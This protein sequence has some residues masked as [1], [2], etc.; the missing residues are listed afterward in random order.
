[1]IYNFPSFTP[2]FPPVM[3]Y[4]ESDVIGTI[5]YTLQHLQNTLHCYVLHLMVMITSS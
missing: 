3:V 5:M 2:D 4:A 1:M